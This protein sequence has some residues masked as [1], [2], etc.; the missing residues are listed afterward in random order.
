MNTTFENFSRD[1]H[2]RVSFGNHT[3]RFIIPY[4]TYFNSTFIEHSTFNKEQLER[5][6][7]EVRMATS[8]RLYLPYRLR[9]I[10][11]TDDDIQVFGD[12]SFMTY[13]LSTPIRWRKSA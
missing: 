2:I 8:G 7:G 6:F 9:K 5:L 12:S 11:V 1:E 3:I 13:K 10:A 4:H